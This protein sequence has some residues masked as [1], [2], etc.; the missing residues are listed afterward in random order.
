MGMIGMS[1][2]GMSVFTIKNKM[3]KFKIMEENSEIIKEKLE[4]VGYLKKKITH[5][6]EN[7]QFDYNDHIVLSELSSKY[8][9]HFVEYCRLFDGIFINSNIKITK[10]TI[11][12]LHKNID[13]SMFYCN[14]ML[15]KLSEIK[16]KNIESHYNSIIQE[17]SSMYNNYYSNAG[18]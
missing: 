11:E 9:N 6:M 15:I 3:Y 8:I 2:V 18:Q 16:S 1:M 10:K 5:K 7:V 12:D 13:K 14:K 17:N 4:I